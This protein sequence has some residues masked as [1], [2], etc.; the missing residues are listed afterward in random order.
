MQ[1]NLSMASGSGLELG[2]PLPKRKKYFAKNWVSSIRA[3]VEF[4]NFRG[5]P[6]PDTVLTQTF[7][8]H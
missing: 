5:S 1:H 6:R 4:L 7:C 2:R 8:D 3:T